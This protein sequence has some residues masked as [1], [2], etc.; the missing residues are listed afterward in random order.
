MISWSSFTK[1]ACTYVYGIHLSTSNKN[2]K[3][4]GPWL[5]ETIRT[6][7]EPKQLLLLVHKICDNLF[8]R[9]VIC[10]GIEEIDYMY[11]SDVPVLQ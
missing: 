5:L 10:I 6:L 4:P 9:L 2:N 1:I 11:M 8:L 3:N 7:F